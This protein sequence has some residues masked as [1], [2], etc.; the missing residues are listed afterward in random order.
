MIRHKKGF[1]IIELIVVLAVLVVLAAIAIPMYIN[2][3]NRAKFEADNASIAI[4]NYS[5]NVYK[6]NEDIQSSDVFVGVSNDDDRLQL[7]VDQNYIATMVYPQQDGAEFNWI[8]ADQ[9][10]TLEGGL[11]LDEESS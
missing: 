3:Q 5:T 10:W 6:C 1:T 4:L 7:L 9:A 11:D 8:V 2:V